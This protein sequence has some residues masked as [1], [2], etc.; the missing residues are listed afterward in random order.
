MDN[1]QYDSVSRNGS[2]EAFA[3][4]KE[5]RARL[6]HLRLYLWD[7]QDSKQ[8][9]LVLSSMDKLTSLDV[10]IQKF[11]PDSNCRLLELVLNFRAPNMDHGRPWITSLRLGGVDFTWK[12]FPRLPGAQSLKHLQLID[13]TNHGDFLRMLST[14]SLNL[15]TFIVTDRKTPSWNWVPNFNN[16]ANEFIRSLHTLGHLSLTLDSKVFQPDTLLDW[17]TLHGHASAVQFLKVQNHSMLVPYR[18][19]ENLSDFRRFC[20]NASSLEQFSISGIVVPMDKTLEDKHIYGSLEQFLV[21]R[22]LSS[23]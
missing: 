18:S 5:Y 4:D 1:H 2:S 16:D 6:K 17:S 15:A 10:S 21:S 13:C 14:L 8:A 23:Y 9:N 20:Q 7:S 22:N 19:D 11:C 12:S 3:A